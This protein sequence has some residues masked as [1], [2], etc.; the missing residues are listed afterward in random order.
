MTTLDSKCVRHREE[1]MIVLKVT[2]LKPHPLKSWIMNERQGIDR[3][4]RYWV[5]GM[6]S[7][8]G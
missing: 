2:P 6:D 4:P 8:V 7:G 3:A 1:S 5:W